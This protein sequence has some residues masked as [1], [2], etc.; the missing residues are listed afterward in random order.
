MTLKEI[1]E[2]AKEKGVKAGKL[3][4]DEL[5]RAIQLAEGNFD[6]YG[7]AVAGDCSQTDC[8]WRA[9]CLGS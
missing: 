6:C 2:I 9:D 3:K 7:T 5:I 4:K 8:F 1:R